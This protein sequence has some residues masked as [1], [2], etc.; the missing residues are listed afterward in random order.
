MG[1]PVIRYVV[2]TCPRSDRANLARLGS[3]GGR[4]FPTAAAAR[5]AARTDA[6]DE[7]CHI[8]QETARYPLGG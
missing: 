4:P 3:W 1:A 5:E 8:A 7:P 6:G 2:T